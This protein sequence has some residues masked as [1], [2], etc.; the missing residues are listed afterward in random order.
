MQDQDLGI[1]VSIDQDRDLQDELES[2]DLV[3]EITT[4][5]VYG[6]ENVDLKRGSSKRL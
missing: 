3:L 5:K 1:K 2:R 4:L 6:K